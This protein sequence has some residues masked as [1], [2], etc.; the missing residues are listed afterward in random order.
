MQEQSKQNTTDQISAYSA[1]AA[2]LVALLS[3]VATIISLII[4]RRSAVASE[5]AAKA[6][7]V[8]AKQQQVLGFY[9]AWHGTKQLVPSR[10]DEAEYADEIIETGNLLSLTAVYWKFEII[11]RTII[12]QEFWIPF[13]SLYRAFAGRETLIAK[14]GKR[15]IDFLTDDIQTAHREMGQLYERLQKDKEKP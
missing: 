6:A 4:A 1:L 15:G 5:E 12:A 11:E 3:L 9:S 10:F 14:A 2:A 8:I 13:D 7:K